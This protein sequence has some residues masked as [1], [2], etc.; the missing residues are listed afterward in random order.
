MEKDEA[1]AFPDTTAEQNSVPMGEVTSTI[2]VVDLD[3][4]NITPE[5]LYAVFSS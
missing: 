1:G 2:A 5:D 3:S 4:D